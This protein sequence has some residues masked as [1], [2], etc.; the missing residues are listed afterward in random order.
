MYFQYFVIFVLHSWYALDWKA[1]LLFFSFDFSNI[2]INNGDWL[3]LEHYKQRWLI[4]LSNHLHGHWSKWYYVLT[5][6]T[7]HEK[8]SSFTNWDAIVGDNC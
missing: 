8:S 4:R 3:L 5:P 6:P 2:K 1:F 7:V